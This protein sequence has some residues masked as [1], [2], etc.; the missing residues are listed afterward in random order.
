VTEAPWNWI[1]RRNKIFKAVV[2]TTDAAD[3]ALRATLGN[4]EKKNMAH[5]YMFGDLYF[6]WALINKLDSFHIRCHAFSI[7]FYF[8][9]YLNANAMNRIIY[10]D[11]M[12]FRERAHTKLSE[13]Q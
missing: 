8:K 1:V 7:H 3:Y 4:I 10:Y 6:S 12:Q 9:P 5:L 13:I 11:T 2:S